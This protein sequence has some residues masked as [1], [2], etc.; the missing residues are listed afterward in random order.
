MK[1]LKLVLTI[2]SALKIIDYIENADK[3][4][5][6][7]DVSEKDWKDN[8][9]QVK[10]EEKRWYIICYKNEIWSDVEKC[11][12]AEKQEYKNVLKML[13]KC[14]DYFYKIYFILKFN[15]NILIV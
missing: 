8:L 4:I 1:I 6:T 10:Q 3:I 11:Y 7:V 13:K 15:V 5:C 9:M 2:I 12:D 14:H